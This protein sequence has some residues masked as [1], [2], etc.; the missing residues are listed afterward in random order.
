MKKATILLALF[1]ATPFFS[2]NS[3]CTSSLHSSK[4]QIETENFWIDTAI[5]AIGTIAGGVVGEQA[6]GLSGALIGFLTG[7]VTG[8]AVVVAKDNAAEI[9]KEA[10]RIKRVHTHEAKG[11]GGT[12]RH[13]NG[14]FRELA[15]GEYRKVY[16]SLLNKTK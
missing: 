15:T 4:K 1:I 16:Q 2:F 6:M 11:L 10:E 14:V 3:F 7:C 5:I 13:Y 8:V 9:K 12:P